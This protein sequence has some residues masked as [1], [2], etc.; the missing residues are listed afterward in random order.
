MYINIIR[1]LS[2][3]VSFASVRITRVKY[4]CV[5]STFKI[6]RTSSHRH[7]HT[8]THKFAHDVGSRTLSYTRLVFHILWVLWP[9]RDPDE[10]T[11]T[12]L[13]II[14]V[15]LSLGVLFFVVVLVAI[16]PEPPRDAF[17]ICVRI[18]SVARPR[19]KKR[20]SLAAFFPSPLHTPVCPRREFSWPLPAGAEVFQLKA[21][22]AAKS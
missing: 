19:E 12:S 4:Y 21:I 11:T 13:C 14:N 3:S 18:L 6:N 15:M 9:A 8:R 16:S 17:S 2:V 5:F 20:P 10:Y 22:T 1:A 7:T